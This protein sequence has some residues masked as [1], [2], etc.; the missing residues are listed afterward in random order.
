MSPLQATRRIGATALTA[1]FCLGSSIAAPVISEFLARNDSGITDEDGELSDWIEVHNP[2]ATPISLAGYYLTDASDNLTQWQFPAVQLAPGAHLVIF[3]SG[4]DRRDPTGTLHTNFRLSGGGEYLGLIAPDGSTVVHAYAPE[5]P[6]QEPDISYGLA[7]S[8]DRNSAGFFNPPTPGQLNPAAFTALAAT[9]TFSQPTRT[10]TSPFILTLSGAGAG[11]VIRFTNDRSF[12]TESSPIYSGPIPLTDGTVQIRAAVFAGAGAG[13]VTTNTYLYL[14]SSSSEG[15]IGSTIRDFT[16]DLPI[17]VLDNFD[18]GRPNTDREMIWTIF[19]PKTPPGGGEARASL[20]NS[21]DLAT[22]GRMAVRGSSTFNNAKYSLRMEAWDEFDEDTNISP[23]G[24]PPES[25]WVLSGRFTFDQAL[26]RNPLIYSLSNDIGRFAMRTRFVEVFIS[27]DDDT[28]STADYFGVYSLIESIKRDDNRIDVQAISPSDESEPEITGGY[29]FK[30][31]RLGPGE[32]GFRV[33]ASGFRDSLAWVEPDEDDVTSAQSSYL[34]GYFND[35]ND[36]LE[37]PD[38]IDPTTGLHFSELLDVPA[39][40]DHHWLNVLAMNVDG[41]RLSGYYYKDRLGPIVAAPIWDFD[42]TMG[43]TDGR[44]ANPRQW[45][46]TGDSSKTWFDTRYPWFGRLLGYSSE[47]QQFPESASTRPDIFQQ[48]ADRWFELRE[49]VFANDFI[50]ARIDEFAAEIEEGAERNFDQWRSVAP[51]RGFGSAVDNLK[52]WLAERTEWIDEQY[53]IKP[54][55]TSQGGQVSAGTSVGATT[56]EIYAT[57]DGSDPRASGGEPSANAT[58]ISSVTESTNVIEENT[59][60]RYLVP[61]SATDAPG[62]TWTVPGFDDATWS[63]GILGLGFQEVGDDFSSLIRTDLTDAMN[64]VN[65]SAYIRVPF[66]L[67]GDLEDVSLIRL[68]VIVDDGFIA[69]LN[70][71]RIGDLNP[72]VGTPAWDSNAGGGRTNSEVVRAPAVVDATAFKDQLQQG[73]NILALHLLNLSAS[74]SDAVISP[75]LK[76]GF[77]LEPDPLTID[78]TTVVTARTRG[79]TAWGP[80]ARNYYFVG[81]TPASA[82]NVVVSEIMYHPSSPTAAEIAAGFDDEDDFEYVEFQNI[83]SLQV[84]LLGTNFTS[85]L[86]FLAGPDFPTSLAPGEVL[87]IVADEAAFEARYGSGLP[88]AGTFAGSQLSNDGEGLTIEDFQGAPI[89]SFAYNDVAPWPTAADGAGFS[90]ELISPGSDPDPGLASSWRASAAP[91]G[92]PGTGALIDGETALSQFITTN[93]LGASDGDNDDDGIADLIEFVFG[94]DP[95]DPSSTLDE[96]RFSAA[97]TET[98]GGNT[99]LTLTVRTSDAA[100]GTTRRPEFSTD[101]QTW[102]STGISIVGTPV[103]V[104]GFTTTTYR[105]PVLDP[106]ASAFLRLAISAP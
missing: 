12:P 68:E 23:L 106:S 4:K 100:T 71:T 94:T 48:H 73:E 91:G 95:N 17:V 79:L 74:N 33:S 18:T 87:L 2:D 21:P 5:F 40:I 76:I 96:E 50:D 20:L 101:L 14:N 55:F 63:L 69:Y 61:L 98:G 42:R 88:V 51:P 75:T 9:V 54:T 36:A 65:A 92:T 3:A 81:E 25:D 8:S 39:W 28:I 90:L 60:C 89:K 15:T 62:T 30:R 13:P 43:S 103:S 49:G 97:T 56:D 19:E 11:Q 105:T 77:P 53:P 84:S 44:D 99:R 59:I 22:R 10:F 52:N 35:M 83:S 41:F 38:G 7:G 66:T 16:S 26:M 72:P 70:G 78:S 86:S 104:D 80:A 6:P 45:D 32:R 67:S 37:A 24:L 57:S 46:G 85:G 82:S 29:L 34:A 93:N 58:A 1:F 47:D 102:T 27:T 64:D 31:D